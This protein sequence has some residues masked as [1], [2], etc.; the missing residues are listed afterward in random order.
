MTALL[1]GNRETA[2]LA[3]YHAL[4]VIANASG[5]GRIVRQG[6]K[7]G[8]QSQGSVLIAAGETKII[9]PFAEPTRHEVVCVDGVLTTGIAPVDFPTSAEVTAMIAAA[10]TAAI[11]EGDNGDVWTIVDG[12]PAW[13]PPA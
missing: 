10:I 6:D 4:T 3:A 7:A 9:G 12:V 5:S 11:G 2:H 13:A 8:E 1:S